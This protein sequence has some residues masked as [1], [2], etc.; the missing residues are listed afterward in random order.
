M[1]ADDA[2]DGLSYFLIVLAVVEPEFFLEAPLPE[3]RFFK[4][5]T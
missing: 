5:A 2:N 1:C 3:H 4:C